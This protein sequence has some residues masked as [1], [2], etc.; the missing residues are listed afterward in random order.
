MT[1]NERH[2]MPY[3]VWIGIAVLIG[4]LIYNGWSNR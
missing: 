4:I 2:D 1:P 3:I